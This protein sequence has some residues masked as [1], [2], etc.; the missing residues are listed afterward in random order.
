MTH[1][2]GLSSGSDLQ[3]DSMDHGVAGKTHPW[4][5]AW[6]QIL[7]EMQ[8]SMTTSLRGKWILKPTINKFVLNFFKSQVDG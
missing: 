8:E 7:Q 2:E 4:A 5:R 3:Q 1:S 6:E